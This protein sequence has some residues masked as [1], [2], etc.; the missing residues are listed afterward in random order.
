[1]KK[2][3]AKQLLFVRSKSRHYLLSLSL[4]L[5][6]LQ[7]HAVFADDPFSKTE[8]LASQGI[9]KVQGIG[10]VCFGLAAVV[11]GLAYGFGG[12]ETKSK[13]KSH[14]IAIALAIFAVSAGPS[15]VEWL[16]NFVKGG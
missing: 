4:F 14:W 13:I 9:S 3:L 11:T 1:M 6:T 8:A 5:A 15:V 7:S 10:I 16:F 2:H 12:R